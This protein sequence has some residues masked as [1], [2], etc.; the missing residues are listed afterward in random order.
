MGPGGGLFMSGA[1][2]QGGRGASGS[3]LVVAVGR[4]HG[5]REGLQC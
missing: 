3:H 5:T 4:G 1:A 2:F